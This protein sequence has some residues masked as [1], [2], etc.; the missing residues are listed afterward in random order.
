M[1]GHRGDDLLLQ[2]V[3]YLDPYGLHDGVLRVQVRRIHLPP[4]G[5][6]GSSHQSTPRPHPRGRA[7]RR[8]ASTPEHRKPQKPRDGEELSS[9]PKS[10]PAPRRCQILGSG[11][12]PPAAQDRVDQDARTE[13][14]RRGQEY[15]RATAGRE[16]RRG[17]P[18]GP[19][20]VVPCVRATGAR[21][22]MSRTAAVAMKSW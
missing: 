22:S 10:D 6:C 15:V 1:H 2:D 21:T 20:T 17:P 12:V 9:V 3:C 8:E 18:N 4:P 7:P 5:A 13:Q 14:Q 19:A 11:F 16:R